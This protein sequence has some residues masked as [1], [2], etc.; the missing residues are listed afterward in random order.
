MANEM[1]KSYRKSYRKGAVGALMDELERAAQELGRLIEDLT[2]DEFQTVCNPGDE[3][4]CSIQAVINHVV[5]AGYAHANHLRVAFSMH[6]SRPEVPLGTRSESVEQLA[7][8]LAYMAA[9][10][11]GRWE[12]TDEQIEAVEIKSQWGT[13]YDL[14]QMLE[15]TVVHVL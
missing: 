4:L 15:H 13:T 10:L 12:M 5:R 3:E 9:T 14:E 6:G 11:E 2:D 1:N 8:M 7:A